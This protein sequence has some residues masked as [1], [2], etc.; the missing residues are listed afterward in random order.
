LA[1]FVGKLLFE[2]SYVRARMTCER[3]TPKSA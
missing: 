2:A 1:D 3:T